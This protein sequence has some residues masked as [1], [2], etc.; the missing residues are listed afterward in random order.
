MKTFVDNAGRTWTVQVNVDAIKR[1]RDLVQVNLL[2]AIEGKLVERLINDPILLCDVLY[3]LCK[4]EA[5]AKNLSDVDFGRAMGGD[6]IDGAT[7]ALLEALVDFFPQ[8]RRRVLSKALAKL[9]NLQVRALAAVEAKLDSPEMERQFAESLR[10][11]ESGSSS[12]SAP[13]S[14][15]SNPAG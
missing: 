4:P 6:A 7:T 12:G 13:A 14:S 8:G 5:D 15:A 2:E 11:I 10:Q 9:N 1:V 3:C